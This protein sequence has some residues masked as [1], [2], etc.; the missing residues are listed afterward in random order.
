MIGNQIK[1][2]NTLLSENLI[3][4]EISDNENLPASLVS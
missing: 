3:Y 2:L 1:E 4:G